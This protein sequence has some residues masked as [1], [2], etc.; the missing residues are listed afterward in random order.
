[1]AGK[2]LMRTRLF[3]LLLVIAAPVFAAERPLS[4]NGFPHPVPRDLAQI[5][6]DAARTYNVDPN[7]VAAVAFHESRFNVREVSPI[8]ATGLMQLLP[9]TGRSLGVSDLFD[10]RQNIFA[11][12]KYLKKQLDRFNGDVD[13][14]LAAYTAG[15]TNVKQNGPGVASHYVATVKSLYAAALHAL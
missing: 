13:S 14:A 6:T 4:T 9:A 1:M 2:V 15:Y 10:P 12:T 5:I 8:G 7:L 11:G 3:A